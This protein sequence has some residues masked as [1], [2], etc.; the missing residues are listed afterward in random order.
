MLPFLCLPTGTPVGSKRSRSDTFTDTN[1]KTVESV[2]KKQ[3]GDVDKLPDELLVNMA[4]HI[5]KSG[6]IN[7]VK[8]L[9]ALSTRFKKLCD[10]DVFWKELCDVHDWNRDDRRA[11]T[12]QNYLLQTTEHK[13]Y[14]LFWKGLVHDNESLRK[15]VEDLFQFKP[16]GDIKH[17][18]YGP[19]DI[20]DTSR[21]TDMSKLFVGKSKFNSDISKWDTSAVTNMY[22]MFNGAEL[23]NQD[24]S[25]WDT[26]NVENMSEMFYDAEAFNQDITKWDTSKVTDMSSMF[27]N[28]SV[29][30]RDIVS[31][32][33]TSS[34]RD[35]GEIFESV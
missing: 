15:A 12:S 35:I 30:N 4:A 9:C 8:N 13:K 19:I 29:F 11:W 16:A 33:N 32:W 31:K 2:L 27:Y 26:S 14:Y 28:A 22:S 18:K 10:K 5:L 3:L 34:V 20:W 23:F 7:S 1:E 24:I 17:S 25:K 21:V 6:G